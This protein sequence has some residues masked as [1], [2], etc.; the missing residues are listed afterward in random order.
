MTHR[1]P[2][3]PLLFCDSV[4]GGKMWGNK[5]DLQRNGSEG[6][7]KKFR[8]ERK[9]KKNPTSIL[10]NNSTKSRNRKTGIQSNRKEKGDSRR[11]THACSHATASVPEWFDSHPLHIVQI[12]FWW[13]LH[14]WFRPS[15]GDTSNTT[16]V[17]LPWVFSFNIFR[18]IVLNAEEDNAET[19]YLNYSTCVIN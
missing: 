2:F 7:V 17:A 10:L 9:K 16:T 12:E 11:F 14:P 4:S 13:N 8:E 3:Q 5:H 1:G 15:C 18:I 19:G 6:V